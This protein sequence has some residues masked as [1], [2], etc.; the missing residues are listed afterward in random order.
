[1]QA[2][3]TTVNEEII[4]WFESLGD[5]TFVLTPNRRLSR[6]VQ[7]QY[8]GYQRSRDRQ[9]WPT[10]PC[11]SINGW[12]Q[13]L[14]EQLQQSYYR[15]CDRILLKPVQETLI[16]ERII[17]QSSQGRNLLNPRQT[18]VV[19]VDAWHKSLQWQ[20][21][22]ERF[23]NRQADFALFKR[24]ADCYRDVCRDSKY[25]DSS[26]IISNLQQALTDSMLPL[27]NALALYGFDVITPKIQGLL[28]NFAEQGVDVYPVDITRKAEVRRIQL[29]DEDTE[30]L[31]A[32]RWA[33]GLLAKH[34]G[35]LQL[36]IGIVVPQL[37]TL[38]TRVERLLNN[39]FEP[40]HLLISKARHVSGFN[41][42][43]AQPLAET[44]LVRAALNV[45]QLNRGELDMELVSHILRSPFIGDPK[46][47]GRR[48]ILDAELR[49]RA[50]SIRI[51]ALRAAA[52]NSGG[53]NKD[54]TSGCPDLFRRLQDFNRLQRSG[55][56]QKRMPSEW[57][58]LFAGQL[59]VLGWPGSR[60]LDSLEFQQIHH[61]H[62][63]LEQLAG[64]DGVCGPGDLNAVLVQLRQLAFQ[65]PFHAR[66]ARSPVQVLGMLEAAGMMFDY[67][68]VTHMDDRNWPMAPQPNP[69]IPVRRQM[70]L[71]MPRVSVEAE[72]QFARNMTKRLAGSA[73]Q[74]IF[75]CS[76]YRGDQELRPSPLI[77]DYTCITT[78]Q[79]D[80]VPPVDYYRELYGVTELAATMDDQAPRI[81]GPAA[82]RGGTQIIKDQAACPF[83]ALARHRLHA[84]EIEQA[85]PGISPAEHG[86]LLHR[87]LEN[88]WRRLGSQHELL[89]LG[90]AE[91]DACI[92]EAITESFLILPASSKPGKR[93]QDMEGRRLYAL[94]RTWLDLERKRRPF[95]VAFNESERELVLAGLPLLV[96]YDRVDELEDGSLFVIDYKTGKADIGSWAGQRPDEPQVPIYC[97]A[98]Q[99]RISGAA[100]GL[101]TAAETGFRGIAESG[102]IAPGIKQPDAAGG[103]E[104]AD[105]WRGIMQQ[106]RDVLERLA[107][108][109]LNGYA[110][111]DPKSTAASCRFCPLPG[112]CRIGENT[113]TG[114]YEHGPE[115][116]DAG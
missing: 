108:E 60:N 35:S 52:G 98:N 17:Q 116:E 77:E 61:W 14:W 28:D 1:M 34:N 10:L 59:H 24:W 55:H 106:W 79:L 7:Q 99:D 4:P 70:E 109:F 72:L 32:A 93:L 103:M 113:T 102:A 81:T 12:L 57:A 5:N 75:S 82:V 41:L 21:D 46:E 73:G 97:I 26:Q 76:R 27:P 9:A 22:V 36:Q 13:S 111:V 53:R 8:A 71:Q 38:S 110:A 37:A 64:L 48:A 114:K 68:W 105:D 51:S 67:V 86:R 39:V 6:F 19:A 40:Q 85:Q 107:M 42:S 88:I 2:G 44:P 20:M 3:L 95:S 112:L 100:F 15:D 47:L 45:L 43:A 62:E 25:T 11:Y 96:R 30:I 56:G 33:A 94:A 78:E 50:L 87:A 63:V 49:S 91:L 65:Y 29:D 31:T 89:Q 104:L 92:D 66:T 58:V 69:L 74:V 23:S 83:R 80:L 18:A 16:W 101:L 115:N 90:E 84:R 54:N